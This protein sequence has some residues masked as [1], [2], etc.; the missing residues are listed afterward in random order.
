MR[1]GDGARRWNSV[2]WHRAAAWLAVVVA[3][4]SAGTQTPLVTRL[5]RAAAER[6][7]ADQLDE[8][9]RIVRRQAG[10][11]SLAFEYDGFDRLRR[12]AAS[13]RPAIGLSHDPQ[14]RITQVEVG[15]ALHARY[16]YDYL[17]RVARIGTAVGDIEYAYRT[18]KDGTPQMIRTLPNG[19]KTRWLHGADGHLQAIV[20]V[21]PDDKV[22]LR[23]D[24]TY[25]PD[26]SVA[27]VTESG[28]AGK[29]TVSHEYDTVHR[30]TAVEDSAHGSFR[31]AYDLVG[32]RTRSEGPG[33]GPAVE[34][35][36]DWAGRL[37]TLA[38][39]RCGHDAAGRLT[40]YG[41][42]AAPV[43]CEY[44]GSGHLARVARGDRT[45]EYAHDG[46]GQ[47]ASRTGPAGTTRFVCDPS[48]DAFEPW[49]AVEADGSRTIYLW[50]A[51]VPLAAIRYG[52]VEFFLA[53]Q[54]GSVRGVADAS[55]AVVRR[56]DYD[57]FGVPLA[58]VEGDRLV[59]GFAGLFY[60]PAAGLYLT[61]ARGYDPALGRFLQRDPEHRV[62]V[63]SQQDLSAYVYCGNDP[64]NF[65]D[66]NGARGQPARL[67]QVQRP[68]APR[69]P[70]RNPRRT[71]PRLVPGPANP[72][73]QTAP[74][75][76]PGGGTIPTTYPG[77]PYSMEFIADAVQTLDR[78]I[79]QRRDSFRDMAYVDRESNTGPQL[80]A[81]DRPRW[82]R[83][84]E[85]I[86]Q[87][88]DL[89]DPTRWS[90][91]VVGGRISA[92]RFDDGTGVWAEWESWANPPSSSSGS[93]EVVYD[94]RPGG[95]GGVVY[96]PPE[97]YGPP[98][99]S[100]WYDDGPRIVLRES[101]QPSRVGGVWLGGAAAALPDMGLLAGVAVD[102]NGRLI[103]LS[104][105]DARINLPPLRLDDVVTIF[106][107]V[108]EHGQ[109]P[110]VSI[111]NDPK[112]PNGP[113][114]TVRHGPGTAETYVGWVLFQCDRVLKCYSLGFDNRD[115]KPFRSRVPGFKS[116]T[117]LAH[118]IETADP[119]SARRKPG[120]L[121]WR[122]IW[123]MPAEVSRESAR[124]GSL[125]LLEVP[126][127]LNTKY[128]EIK[129]GEFRDVDRKPD[130]AWGRANTIADRWFT[131]HYDEI[132]EEFLLE[133][134]AE[135][136]ITGP[137]RIFS[138]LKRIATIA[139]VAE[140]L[141]AQGV[142]LPEWMRSY[143]V[144]PCPV[145][146]T[147]PWLTN[148]EV[149][150]R[151]A[152]GTARERKV[153]GGVTLTPP[154]DLVKTVSDS[155][156]AVAV[157]EP[158]TRAAA[159][160]P[161]FQPVTVS[162]PDAEYRAVP[163]PGADTVDLG[164]ARL[165][166]VDLVV[167]FGRGQRLDLVRQFNS[168][169]QPGGPWGPTWTLDLPTLE[170]LI[171]RIKSTSDGPVTRS[172]YRLSS[173]LGSISATLR[174]RK[175]VP[176]LG[177]ETTA[178]D[179]PGGVLGMLADAKDPRIGAATKR[180]AMRDGSNWH[181]FAAA[182]GKPAADDP[183]AGLLAAIERGPTLVAYRWDAAQR[184]AGLEGFF[185]N[186]KQGSGSNPTPGDGS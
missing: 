118:E 51:G 186:E 151:D 115:G 28:A 128:R 32:G 166:E 14:G 109:S 46:D 2:R 1:G 26:G 36:Y 144:R 19:I 178:P 72:A 136:G 102:E 153:T 61:P 74:Y 146:K 105:D 30:L 101:D 120:D 66:V 175:H 54:L 92:P 158:I 35:A 29:R 117:Q 177:F 4:C 164:A 43:R 78:I 160:A 73:W 121:E 37:V 94:H 106:R 170:V 122:R 167:P 169:F 39:E 176:E 155:P 98:L 130:N 168:F 69:P 27:E 157:A 95:G 40:A 77:A 31:Y 81:D 103:L 13:D 131:E 148:V 75:S 91:D 59:P 126:L 10:E 139:A 145:D 42:P 52:E 134:P 133:P 45:V 111:D 150:V 129:D 9:G 161:I 172:Y 147:S 16:D 58:G 156:R 135:T 33:G 173:P 71:P 88:V 159:A 38:G 86:R 125:T 64:V 143:P 67:Q 110:Y 83:T 154:D 48:S 3:G 85:V 44:A 127:M 182:E 62:P 119:D 104:E 50:E 56:Q 60:D 152:D 162:T 41:P 138:E 174:E 116:G 113:L 84:G 184:L 114:C 47:L 183:R 108:Y 123:I 112:N 82:D 65:K 34:A 165:A 57:P 107:C 180:V 6:S 140:A 15:D 22:L 141:A 132:A 137:V 79:Q 68:P 96:G 25:R 70:V 5:D 99:P 11:R 93:G 17:G 179:R 124:T 80:W 20:H 76:I 87:S 55:G 53:D 12:I 24:Y 149:P 8:F 18:S 97:P 63:G 163:L 90:I 181:F 171:R 7:A 89:N 21:G 49:M 100:N 23:W 142:P 185:G